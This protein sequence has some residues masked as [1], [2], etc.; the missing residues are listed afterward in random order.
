MRITR[1]NRKHI[2]LVGGGFA[3][4][5]F[6]RKLFNNRYYDV[7]LVDK[8]NYNYFTPLLYQVATGFLEPAAISYPFRKLLAKK[9]I[10]FRMAELV[11]VDAEAGRLYLS[12][13]GELHYDI[14]VF[15]T[16]SKT[17][18][19]GNKAIRRH[20]FSIK[21]IDDALYMRNELIKTLE[22]ASIEKDP[23]EKQKLLTMVIAGGGPTGVELAGMMAELKDCILWKDYPELKNDPVTIHLVE[24]SPNLLQAMSDKTHAAA[25]KALK[26]LGINL[27]LNARVSSYENDSVLLSDGELIKT[28]TLIWAAGVMISP[29]EGI[30]T[31]GMG[32]GNRMV[33][34]HFN[35]LREYDNIYA[36]GDISVQYT[37]S[38][39][40]NGHPLL[41]QPA[42]QQGKTL[43]KNLLLLAK[44]KEMRP[45]KYFDRGEMA[46]IGRK[47]AVA[48]LFK[49]RLHIGGLAGLFAWL[50]IHLISLVN[51]NNKIRTLYS[52]LVAYLTH[53]QVLRMIFKSGEPWNEQE[54]EETRK[55]H[56]PLFT[57]DLPVN[58][59]VDQLSKH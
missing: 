54:K 55:K 11:R 30:S 56:A 22:R 9:G 45:F 48:D 6:L 23:Q 57:G 10:A 28:K 58:P 1:S 31:T 14:L 42:I 29:L 49:H 24:G 4:F 21:G 16:G 53:D 38:K 25:Y 44:G 15:A 52:W 27:K 20:S 17:N 39:Y 35:R 13:G 46:I 36:I 50:F 40:P 12:D 34:D 3:G 18:F 2:V 41:A 43:G 37:D 33:T 5:N 32:K 19:F 26:R 8:N 59:L 51:Y 47:W 7:T